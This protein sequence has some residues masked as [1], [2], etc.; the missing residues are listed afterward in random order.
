M[1][2]LHVI[3]SLSRVHGG[4]T[5]ALALMEGALAEQGVTVETAT[6]DDDGPGRHNGKACG[7]PLQENRALDDRQR[8]PL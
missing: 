6:T 8:Q 3:P 2:V 5:R 4:P 1:K 7:Q